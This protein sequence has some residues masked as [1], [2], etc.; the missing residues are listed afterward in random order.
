[1]K[2]T[3]FGISLALV[4][5][6]CGCAG[7]T[8][9]L[10]DKAANPITGTQL[11]AVGGGTVLGAAAGDAIGGRKGAVIGGALGLAGSA[12]TYNAV[13]NH[14]SEIATEAEAA[15]ERKGR[16]EVFEQMWDTEAR[17]PGKPPSESFGGTTP[18]VAYPAQ[19]IEGVKFAPRQD[20]GQPLQVPER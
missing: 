11:A 18:L 1:M 20:T 16:I 15:G 5:L 7:P 12:L 9:P 4:A 14:D 10:T 13:A 6:L 19:T 3:S 8:S 17:S 2:T